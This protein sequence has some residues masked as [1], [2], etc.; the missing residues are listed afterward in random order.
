MEHIEMAE[1]LRDKAGV[2]YEDAKMALEEANWDMLDAMVLLEKQGKINRLATTYS[3]K[4]EPPKEEYQAPPKSKGVG[5]MV[6]KFFK[7][8][9]E[10]IGKGN[11]NN[12]NVEKNGERVFSIP[13][14]VFVLLLII[15]P[16]LPFTLMLL[17]VGL[18]FGFG[19]NFSGPD[20]GRDDVNDV[21]GKASKV[22]DNIKEEFKNATDSNETK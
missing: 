8:L 14:T 12:F 7:W 5:E 13:V 21:M 11:R 10:L 18:F 20:L 4:Q 6:G 2:G 17:V 15:F 3:T 22:A 19:Y 9:G 1:K 16:I